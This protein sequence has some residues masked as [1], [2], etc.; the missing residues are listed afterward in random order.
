MARTKLTDVTIRNLPYPESGNAKYWDTATPG[1]GIRVTPGS[2][3][4]MVMYGQTRQLKT[5]GQYP[6]ISLAA[7]RKDAMRYLVLK[8]EK[9]RTTRLLDARKTYLEECESKNR[10]STVRSY[11]LLLE[12]VAD[13]PL[14]DVKKSDIDISNSHQVMAWKVFFNWCI[15]NELVD[16]NPF[17]G[18]PATYGKRERVLT[19]AEIKAI[20]NYEDKP[21]SDIIKALILTGQRRE[22]ILNFSKT[23]DGFYLPATKSKNKRA[24]TIPATPMVEE[25]LPLPRFNGWGKSK[26]RMDKATGT[27]DW[28]IHD[29]R[30]TYATIHAQLGTPI[31]VVEALLN[32]KSGTVS[33]VAAVYIRHNFMAE[34]QKAALIY[35]AHIAKLVGV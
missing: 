9:E 28:K 29:I 10:P 26:A 21:F 5:L 13:K 24:H 14:S 12:K 19:T 16:R 7:A 2:K 8:P 4:F 11:R 23:D 6:E 25:L 31:H 18:I 30:R 17:I 33:G 22:E 20:W 27:S 1:F 3:S 32:H 35:E 34:A 15:R